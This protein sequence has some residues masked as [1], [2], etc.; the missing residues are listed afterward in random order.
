MPISSSQGAYQNDNGLDAAQ[1]GAMQLAQLSQQPG[2][3]GGVGLPMMQVNMGTGRLVAAMEHLDRIVGAFADDMGRSVAQIR[4]EI[5]AEREMA[6]L[7][8]AQTQSAVEA[9]RQQLASDMLSIGDSSSDILTFGQLTCWMRKSRPSLASVWIVVK[10]NR[11]GQANLT[12]LT[13][14]NLNDNQ[15]ERS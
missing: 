6:M 3:M 13:L 1:H 14:T 2:M 12:N 4:S 7:E 11:H 15:D 5:N 10:V 8:V 9:A